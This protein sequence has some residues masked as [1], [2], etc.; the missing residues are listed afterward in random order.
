MLLTS[1]H[2]HAELPNTNAVVF[3]DL[4]QQA[5][6]R[7][8]LR[9]EALCVRWPWM[10]FPDSVF[11]VL[12]CSSSSGE[13]SYPSDLENWYEL[14]RTLDNSAKLQPHPSPEN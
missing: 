9:R 2:T 7:P 14:P 4:L 10:S 1:G 5:N 3:G 8:I 13:M 11:V 12:Q 6:A